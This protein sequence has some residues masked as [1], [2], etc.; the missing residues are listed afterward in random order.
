[1]LPVSALSPT[2]IY[3][4]PPS[5][6]LSKAPIPKYLAPILLVLSNVSFP[7]SLNK[8]NSLWKISFW[9]YNLIDLPEL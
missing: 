9:L 4:N 1:M 3:T 6:E 2:N 8:S 7:P 5:D